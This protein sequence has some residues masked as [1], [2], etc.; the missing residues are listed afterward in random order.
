MNSESRPPIGE[1]VNPAAPR[2]ERQEQVAAALTATRERVAR[3]ARAVGRPPEAITVIV[4]TKTWPADD[5]RRLAQ[6]GVRDVG[7]NRDQE[8]AA[9]AQSCSDLNLNWHFI[10]QMQRNKAASVARYAAVVHSVDRPTLVPALSRG[11]VNAD[12][13]VD[14]CLQVNLDPVPREGRGGVD[15]DHAAALAADVAASP[16]L[17]LRGVMGVAPLGGDALG[18]FER[19]AT[20]LDRLRE[21]HPGLDMMS[22]GMSGDLEQA[23]AA[24][25]THLRI[26]SAILGSRPPLR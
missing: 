21:E 25:A 15:P 9:K 22:A 26:G 24:G 18:A 20:V 2:D 17:R 1:S 12:R 4:V 14:V 11:A 5:V 13:T 8:A 7:E 23:V 19:L 16:G 6:L 3:A 10:G